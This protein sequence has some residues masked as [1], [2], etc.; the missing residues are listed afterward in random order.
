MNK[1]D[2]IVIGTW[3]KL[4]FYLKLVL[5]KIFSILGNSLEDIFSLTRSIRPPPCSVLS[6][7][8]GGSN[9]CKI[10]WLRG[11]VLSSLHG[12]ANPCKTN[13]LRG[14]VLFN[15]VWDVS[16]ISIFI[17]YFFNFCRIEVIFIWAIMNKFAFLF[18]ISFNAL[19][20]SVSSEK[21]SFS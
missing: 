1:T 20:Y 17:A 10:N 19:F 11:D 3:N 7:L 5:T 8:Y 18:H 9:P 12:G 2:I 21:V 14:D 16:K 6:S 13:W 4:L 15:F